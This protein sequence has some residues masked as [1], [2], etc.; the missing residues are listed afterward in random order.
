METGIIF[1]EIK[2]K[3]NSAKN[4]DLIWRNEVSCKQNNVKETL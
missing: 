3:L 2:T 1:H 4:L